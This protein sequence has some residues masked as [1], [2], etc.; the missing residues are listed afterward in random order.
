MNKTELI[1]KV[2]EDCGLSQKSVGDCL[3]S[4]IEVIQGELKSGGDVVIPGFGSFSVGERAARTARNFQTGKMMD[5]PAT[6][7]VKFKVGK[8][9][10][11]SVK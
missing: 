5:I 11:E 10:K 3:N 1:H 6:K 2:A 8:T 4:I 9:L 7:T